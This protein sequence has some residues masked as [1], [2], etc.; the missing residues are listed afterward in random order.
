MARNLFNLGGSVGV[1]TS[2]NAVD[3]FPTK[4]AIGA[5]G[6]VQRLPVRLPLPEFSGFRDDNPGA[7]DERLQSEQRLF[8]ILTVGGDNE[9]KRP[10]PPTLEDNDGFS[11][12]H[13][14]NTPEVFFD[15]G[16]GF[17]FA[18][19]RLANSSLA[20]FGPRGV[21]VSPAGLPPIDS[22]LR[23]FGDTIEEVRGLRVGSVSG[24]LRERRE[25]GSLLR[26]L[27]DE[28]GHR[29]QLLRKERREEQLRGDRDR[30]LADRRRS[31]LEESRFGLLRALHEEQVQ[32]GSTSRDL[33]EL[34]ST[35][36]E[37]IG[38]LTSD[39]STLRQQKA[40]LESELQQLTE[41][42]FQIQAQFKGAE[43]VARDEFGKLQQLSG[44]KSRKL[45]GVTEQL[46][47]VKLQLSHVT[48]QLSEREREIEQQRSNVLQI[49]DAHDTLKTK[50]T[51]EHE[52]VRCMEGVVDEQRKEIERL[53]GSAVNGN[54]NHSAQLQNLSSSLLEA[55]KQ[56]QAA[57][58]ELKLTHA[59]FAASQ[60]Q[61]HED[62]ITAIKNERTGYEQKLQQHELAMVRRLE[63]AGLAAR[64]E[65]FRQAESRISEINEEARVK[66]DVL[67]NHVQQLES[68]I[69]SGDKRLSGDLVS[70]HQ[71]VR[72][73]HTQA[74]AQ[75]DTIHREAADTIQQL[76]NQ[77]AD[78]QARVEAF[79]GDNLLQE[80]RFALAMQELKSENDT[81]IAHAREEGEI[82]L[83]EANRSARDISNLHD[84]VAE[85]LRSATEEFQSQT[86][87]LLTVRGQLDKTKQKLRN[88]EA[89]AGLAA[90][91]KEKLDSLNSYVRDLEQRANSAV[92]DIKIAEDRARSAEAE[93]QEVIEM[94]RIFS[95]QKDAQVEEYKAS[96]EGQL[97]T[98]EDKN[99]ELAEKIGDSS[100]ENA[101]LANTVLTSRAAIKEVEEKLLQAIQQT[102]EAS[103]REARAI[104]DREVLKTEV[105]TAKGLIQS[106]EGQNDFSQELQQLQVSSAESIA[107]LKQELLKTNAKLEQ[108]SLDLV[109]S[110][111][112][113]VKS[114][115]VDE[116]ETE[117][118][119]LKNLI[120]QAE[121][122][123]NNNAVLPNRPQLLTQ[124]DNDTAMLQSLEGQNDSSK[125]LQQLQVS[126]AMNIASLQQRL[127]ETTSQFEQANRDLVASQGFADKAG[128]VEE[129][130]NEV[131]NLKN[132]I[133][134]AEAKYDDSVLG[135]RPLQFGALSPAR[136]AAVPLQNELDGQGRQQQRQLK[137]SRDPEMRI[138]HRPPKRGR[139][140][141]LLLL[142]AP[143][144]GS[145][146][147][148]EE[149]QRLREVER[150][151]EDDNE[152]VFSI[153]G[154]PDL[155]VS[156]QTVQNVVNRVLREKHG[157]TV[158]VDVL[159]SRLRS[160]IALRELAHSPENSAAEVAANLSDL[161]LK[162][163]IDQAR[164]LLTTLATEAAQVSDGELVELAALRPRR[165]SEPAQISKH[166]MIHQLASRGHT[167]RHSGRHL[168]LKE[169]HS[170]LQFKFP[171]G[172]EG[173]SLQTITPT[174]N[175]P[176][177]PLR[178]E[179]IADDSAPSSTKGA[180][181]PF[182][183]NA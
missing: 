90:E 150:K 182:G 64:E 116:L 135:D 41:H 128:R 4:F 12:E 181:V 136:I 133:V 171:A 103:S 51:H 11:K 134:Q 71:M 169:D 144:D 112:A 165:K 140:G 183:R 106:L 84:E 10:R 161:L 109:A 82:L 17:Q 88:A 148:L 6:Q 107:A 14:H 68:Q 95:A 168:E 75:V 2:F 170:A 146:E 32:R 151:G 159:S 160:I 79:D 104:G 113:P 21:I 92:A 54:S 143:D 129:L 16:Q 89:K 155:Q 74:T 119:N 45:D 142:A 157:I 147:L 33:E 73:A 31:H 175:F 141:N 35:A 15:D 77:L 20:E 61:Q 1:Q 36:N 57:Q 149:E 29:V 98:L 111:G 166:K 152:K 127:L 80:R 58:E 178:G 65:V 177:V 94:A 13:K 56:L 118:A 110:Q 121:V 179:A 154:R 5:G 176:L 78:S 63:V 26:E 25:R 28:A 55:Q 125:E 101:I 18:G 34:K 70:A 137:R 7:L 123:N 105:D 60:K 47:E 93:K 91:T 180:L 115:R 132:F 162:R 40:S 39:V 46:K 83:K 131:A 122:E 49:R 44:D 30:Q 69:A 97:Q 9:E 23:L 3:L 139:G 138:T 108:A 24:A 22:D 48:D 85:K 156:V 99:K 66:N 174:V 53:E 43:I 50:L 76:R 8:R 67:L 38:N 37:L 27:T 153:P 87:H 172:F 163:N 130:E 117:V 114:G 158:G 19:R 52:R 59:R 102:K 96:L 126:S 164:N 124:G 62:S 81:L 120:D 173:S 42:V 167:G 100:N 86:A 145:V 72:D